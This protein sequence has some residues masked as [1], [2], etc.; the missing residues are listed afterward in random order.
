MLTPSVQLKSLNFV[1]T[2]LNIGIAS[3][4]NLTSRCLPALDIITD[5]MS[6]DTEMMMKSGV[7]TLVPT[8]LIPHPIK[9]FHTLNYTL[10]TIILLSH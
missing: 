6:K 8:S 1:I 3:F 9:Y 2:L 5:K 10:K 7:V 4:D